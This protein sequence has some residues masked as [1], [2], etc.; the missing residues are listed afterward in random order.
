[1]NPLLRTIL[2]MLITLA[3]PAY[4]ADSQFAAAFQAISK[5]APKSD[6][7]SQAAFESR[8]AA[9]L[10]GAFSIRRKPHYEN[11]EFAK[12]HENEIA[13]DPETQT[14][15]AK[16]YGDSICICKFAGS[17]TDVLAGDYMYITVT[18]S[19]STGSYVGQNAF[20]AKAKVRVAMTHSQGVVVTNAPVRELASS[21]EDSRTIVKLTFPN[22]TASQ[23]R[24]AV[25]K[26]YFILTFQPELLGSA[27]R[28][29]RRLI[30]RDESATEA[31]T[32]QTPFEAATE[33]R[34]ITAKLSRVQFFDGTGAAPLFDK[35]TSDMTAN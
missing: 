20:G 30:G 21:Y 34:L 19:T 13:Y 9:A 24:A 18:G 1:M 6:F 27:S 14:L 26:G 8:V 32:I 12:Q 22:I 31:A 25:S 17:E 33:T 11:D 7:E 28:P 29:T 10:P 2:A 4:G 3:I 16:V 15:T 23:A 5:I 35:A